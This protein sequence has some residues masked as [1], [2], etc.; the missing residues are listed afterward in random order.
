M[1]ASLKFFAAKVRSSVDIR[2][3]SLVIRSESVNISSGSN[4]IRSASDVFRS[5]KIEQTA[6]RGVK[7]EKP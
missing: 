3:E 1:T 2:T 6:I 5:H 4:A 7:G